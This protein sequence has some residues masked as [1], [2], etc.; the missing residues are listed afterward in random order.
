MSGEV[1]ARPELGYRSW[2]IGVVRHRRCDLSWALAGLA[3]RRVVAP[4]ASGDL[5]PGG[6]G[7]DVDADNVRQARGGELAGKA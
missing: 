7:V 2:M 4:G 1:V 5:R 3:K 6:G